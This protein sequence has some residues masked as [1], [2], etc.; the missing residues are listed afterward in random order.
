GSDLLGGMH[1]YQSDEFILRGRY[2]PA[3]EVVRS[4]TIYAAKAVRAEGEIG[5]VEKNAH[6]DLIVVDGDPL[7]DLSLLT[8]Q[9]KHLPMIMKG[10][11]FVKREL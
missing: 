7:A 4:A 2:L 6:A 10:G 8:G 9:G 11:A 1:P 5:I 3:M